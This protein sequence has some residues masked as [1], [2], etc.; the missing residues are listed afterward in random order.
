MKPGAFSLV[1]SADSLWNFP[2]ISYFESYK[3]YAGAGFLIFWGLTILIISIAILGNRK[4][5]RQLLPV[6]DRQSMTKSAAE[7]D[8][9][10]EQEN[11]RLPG[12]MTLQPFLREKIRIPGPQIAADTMSG[13]PWLRFQN[14]SFPSYAETLAHCGNLE[15]ISKHFL[16]SISDIYPGSVSELY[17]TDGSNLRLYLTLKG[18]MFLTGGDEIESQ[19]SGAVYEELKTGRCVYIDE[20]RTVCFPV[21]CREGLLGS[22][23]LKSETSIYRRDAVS[24]IWNECRNFGGLVYQNAVFE[25][26][27][28]D[29]DSGLWNGLRF[30]H[31]LGYEFS[32]RNSIKDKRSLALVYFSAA[33]SLESARS[34][35]A[36]SRITFEPAFRAYRIARD[37][38]AFLGPQ[39]DEAETGLRFRAFLGSLRKRGEF[40]ICAGSAALTPDIYSADAWFHRA[41]SALYTAAEAGW[42][43]Y[44]IHSGI[45]DIQF[46][47]RSAVENTW[48]R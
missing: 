27:S 22:V 3:L 20:G 42:N 17:L 26:T 18:S 10:L 15:S 9:R 5:R 14:F 1:S 11:W 6:V 21:E 40:Q 37:S 36:E 38:I 19:V 28:V 39:E 47:E 31:D 46:T 13:N 41:A 30:H 12:Y 24:R 7:D 8:G 48:I 23:V 34:A 2:L 45:S 44:F 16:V 25:Q 29:P 32:L 4:R 33:M 35:G 43:C